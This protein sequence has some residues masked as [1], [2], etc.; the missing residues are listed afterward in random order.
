M[1]P[2]LGILL[3]LAAL[4]AL[5]GA[6]CALHRRFAFH[7][8]LSRKLAHIASG[9]V[10]ASFPFLFAE[11]LPVL[12][13]AAISLGAML[14]VRFVKPLRQRVGGVIHGVERQSCGE[15]CLPLSVAILFPLTRNSPHLFYIP[16][17]ILAFADA[18]SALIGVRYGMH[19][20]TTDEG[21]KSIEGSAA[22]FAV[23]FLTVAIPLLWFGYR[24]IADVLAIAATLG[25]LVMILEAVAWRGLD[26][27][28]IPLGAFALLSVYMDLT[29]AQ[30]MLRLVVTVA[31]VGFAIWWRR[32]T[33]LTTSAVLGATFVLYIVWALAGWRWLVPPLVLFIGYTLLSPR[34]ER[35]SLRIHGMDAVL[36]VASPSLAWLF[37]ARSL[38]R[39][40]LVYPFTLAFAAHLSIIGIARLAFDYP[41]LPRPLLFVTCVL[42]GWL[43]VFVPYWFVE[44]MSATVLTHSL[45]AVSGVAAAALGFLLLQPK[46]NDC[47]TDAARWIR[48]GA[49]AAFGS[50]IGLIPLYWF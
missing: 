8:E 42:K 5:L 45:F 9:L 36:C 13:L 10:A 39:P 19:K 30:L 26:N 28:F 3:V 37:A 48:Q 14:L 32:E 25:L 15:L 23:T 29:T 7:P 49:L 17:L 35:N 47:P 44:N 2:W 6:I 27:L 18:V 22:F 41:R 40:E 50:L 43:F 20:F 16:I 1:N 21:H 24:G 38:S 11:T 12:I 31:L 4:G 46:I 33:T 34:N